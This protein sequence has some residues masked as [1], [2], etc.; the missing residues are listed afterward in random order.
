MCTK[1]EIHTSFRRAV[2]ALFAKKKLHLIFSDFTVM[3]IGHFLTRFINKTSVRS[4]WT[5]SEK[6]LAANAIRRAASIFTI[7]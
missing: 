5:Q 6:S 7:F 3:L 2:T 4:V 1:H